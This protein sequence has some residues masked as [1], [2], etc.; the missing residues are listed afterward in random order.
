MGTKVEWGWKVKQRKDGSLIIIDEGSYQLLPEVYEDTG[1]TAS[2]VDLTFNADTGR[3]SIDGWLINDGPDPLTAAFARDG[4]T[5]SSAFTV[6][7]NET[8]DLSKFDIHTLRLTTA[9]DAA[10]RVVMI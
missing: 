6:S 7:N 9:G 1:F 10:Y 5:Y 4:V 3:N 2:T 8:I